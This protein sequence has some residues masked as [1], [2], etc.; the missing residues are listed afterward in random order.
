MDKLK[1]K[2]PKSLH[3]PLPRE[4]VERFDHKKSYVSVF[5]SLIIQPRFH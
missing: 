4:T 2:V 1:E 3:E 5:M